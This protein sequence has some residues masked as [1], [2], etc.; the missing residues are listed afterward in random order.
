MAG[1]LR[2]AVASCAA[3]RTASV[4]VLALIAFLCGCPGTPPS[5]ACPMALYS[6][7]PSSGV[8]LREATGAVWT[9]GAEVAL[10]FGAQGGFM[11]TP[12]IEIDGALADGD[13]PCL[14]VTLEH[15]DPGGT[16]VFDEFRS[17]ETTEHFVRTIDGDLATGRI[18]DQLRWSPLPAGTPLEITVTVRGDSFAA[19]SVVTVALVPEA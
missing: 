7:A 5:D 2:G 4:L 13:E 8:V 3:M 19:R 12:V 10:V 6:G 1:D 15:R 16:T 11:V 9:T 17:R 18:F 14:R